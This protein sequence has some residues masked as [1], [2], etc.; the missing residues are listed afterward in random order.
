[1]DDE[2]RRKRVLC[3]ATAQPSETPAFIIHFLFSQACPRRNGMPAWEQPSLPPC[4]AMHYRD[5]R[6]SYFMLTFQISESGPLYGVMF[7]K[8]EVSSST[9]LSYAYIFL[10][11]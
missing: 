11:W 3:Q 6:K 2:R 7:W 1:M 10:R 9:L 5:I 8:N 4:G